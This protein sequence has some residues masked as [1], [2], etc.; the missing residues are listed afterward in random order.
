MEKIGDR[1]RRERILKGWNRPDVVKELEKRGIEITAEAIRLYETHQNNPGRAVRAGLA[2]IF[3]KDES[4]LEFGHSIKN[5]KGEEVSG[6]ELQILSGYRDSP[7]EIQQIIEALTIV[8][9]RKP[10]VKIR[11]RS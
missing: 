8:G 7:P 11:K 6:K 2:A 1:I 9:R 10:V 5:G 3:G 4:Y